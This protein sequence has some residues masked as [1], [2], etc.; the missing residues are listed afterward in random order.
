M[1]AWSFDHQTLVYNRTDRWQTINHYWCIVALLPEALWIN[2][3]GLHCWLFSAPSVVINA[4][5]VLCCSETGSKRWQLAVR[6]QR[7]TH[8]NQRQG[9][10]VWCS[11]PKYYT[12]P[13]VFLQFT[14]PFP[15]YQS[16]PAV[17]EVQF[18]LWGRFMWNWCIQFHYIS[19]P[20][21][22]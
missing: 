14:T 3:A 12:L 19:S 21:S 1:T 11:V 22:L 18:P 8:D 16:C 15:E 20:V 6:H 13:A 17:Q 9:D 5:R 2:N 10:T 4:H 7:K